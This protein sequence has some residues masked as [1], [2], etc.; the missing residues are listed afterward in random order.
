M[1][2]TAVVSL[3]FHQQ[4]QSSLEFGRNKESTND[5]DTK[6]LFRTEYP[7]MCDDD[8]VR[9]KAL[10]LRDICRQRVHNDDIEMEDY[11]DPNFPEVDAD[12][13][14]RSST[15]QNVIMIGNK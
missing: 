15:P 8:E 3:L 2:A 10:E 12:T 14:F 7:N 9:I 1:A 4:Q 6:R 13:V 11:F 5:D